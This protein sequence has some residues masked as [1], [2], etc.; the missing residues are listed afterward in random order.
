MTKILPRKR[1]VP[2]KRLLELAPATTLVVVAKLV[3]LSPPKLP[4][5]ATKAATA[6]KLAPPPTLLSHLLPLWLA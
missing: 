6:V 3:E 5:R 4:P 1:G 2:P